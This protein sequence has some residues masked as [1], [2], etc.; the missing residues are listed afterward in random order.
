MNLAHH[1]SEVRDS[2]RRVK[3]NVLNGV[4]AEWLTPQEVKEVCPIINVSDNIGIRSWVRPISHAPGLPHDHVA[5]ALPA[6]QMPRVLTS[7]R[8]PRSPIFWW[9]TVGSPG[10]HPRKILAG[11]VALCGA[12]HSTQLAEMAGIKLPIQS[13]PLQA[14]VSELFEPVHPTVVMSNHI[15]VYV[16]QAH[17]GELVM[18]AGIDTT[19]VSVSAAPSMLSRNRW[20]L[21][22]RLFRSLPEHTCCVPGRHR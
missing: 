4:D 13:H 22:S 18:G 6:P 19:T 12:G 16:S 20:P 8:T 11:Q 10:N 21:P 5:W 9:K 2:V 7:S 1:V 17:K 15:H 3:A 14:L